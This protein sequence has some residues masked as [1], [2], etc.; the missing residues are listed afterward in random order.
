[1]QAIAPSIE[2]IR[3]FMADFEKKH[4]A[5]NRAVRIRVGPKLYY[6]L[7]KQLPLA[8]GPIPEEII[9]TLRSLYGLSVERD[10]SLPYPEYIVEMADGTEVIHGREG[11][12]VR[13]PTKK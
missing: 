8:C 13:Q 12:P 11:G 1:M 9:G 2:S 10:F 3:Q 5:E 7:D 6:D 4:P